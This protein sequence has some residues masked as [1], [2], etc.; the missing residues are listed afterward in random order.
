LGF[1]CGGGGES[2]L[3]SQPERR[4][5]NELANKGDMAMT[6][7]K[8]VKIVKTTFI[9]LYALPPLI[10]CLN[11]VGCV[12]G[13]FM[14][15]SERSKIARVWSDWRAIR[16]GMEAY[17]T[18][19]GV[20]PE[21][22]WRLTTPTTYMGALPRDAFLKDQSDTYRY[23]RFTDQSFMLVSVA[24]NQV[25]EIDFDRDVPTSASIQ[26]L[27]RLMKKSF[28]AQYTGRREYKKNLENGDFWFIQLPSGEL[29]SSGDEM[30]RYESVFLSE[31]SFTTAT[32][33]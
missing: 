33:K 16:R 4:N 15:A 28:F 31:D 7:A 18:E 30:W 20:Y 24:R 5:T 13:N 32:K 8:I 12:V 1:P 27:D 14:E 21:A 10:F 26:R 29:A 11:Q 25:H 9:L 19:H 2:G 22:L 6:K 23:K 3:L 17:Q